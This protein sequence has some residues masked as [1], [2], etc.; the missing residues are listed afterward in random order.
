MAAPVQRVRL[1]AYGWKP[2]PYQMKSWNAWESG[3]KRSLLVWHRRAGKDEIELHKHAVAAHER[4]GTY[5]HMLPEY[6]QARK[7]IWNAVNPHSGKRRI[8]EAFPPEIRASTNDQEMFIRFKSGSTWQVVGSDNYS[9]LVGTP[10]VGLTFSEWARANPAAWA[11]LSPILV[12]NG[13]WASFISTP[14]GRNHLKSML[15]M[16]R[17][18]P[19][20]WFSEV[21]TVADTGAMSVEA[22][23]SQRREYHSLYG[24]DQGDALI[25][26]EYYC[27]FDA[28][29]LGAY[30][31][32]E[33][34]LAAKQGRVCVVP[35]DPNAPVHTAWDLGVGDQM[36]I[37]FWQAIGPEIRI[38]G[39]YASSGYAISHY[40]EQIKIRAAAGGYERG[41]DYV[42][43]DAKQRSMTS[44][45]EDGKA[46]QRIEVMV[47]CGLK[48]QLVPIHRLQDG[49]SAVR[50]VMPRCYFDEALTA[51]GLE[52]LRQYRAEWDDKKKIFTDAPLHNWASH[53]A[54]A[55]R[56][57]AMAYIVMVPTASK[58]KPEVSRAQQ[59]RVSLP[60]APQ[61]RSGVRIK[62]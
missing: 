11:Y 52:A 1:P 62:I 33:L 24:M 41:I 56:T 23:E 9:S 29:I 47:E 22:V 26:Q 44:S 3:R 50:Q 20:E 17:A 30:F 40:A 49:I 34:A 45:G 10:P 38:V 48:P 8:D 58:P 55:F 5:W 53:P 6:S 16:A 31:G 37:W 19:N 27:S 43:H 14:F 25:E 35:V 51:D 42:P 13:G 7:A 46:K 4:I 15:D 28:A 39:Y 61:A 12:E 60:G 36:S 2:R 59:S 21:L 57:M 18:N 54:D 32:K